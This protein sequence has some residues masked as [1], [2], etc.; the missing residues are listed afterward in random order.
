MRKMVEEFNASQD[1]I[2]VEIQYVPD[3]DF[4]KKLALSMTDDTMPDVAL[5]DSADFKY[6]HEMRAFVDLTE[7]VDIWEEYLPEIMECCTIDGRIYGIPVGFNCSVLYYNVNTLQEQNIEVPE[8]WEELYQ[9]AVQMSQGER[10][11]FAIPAIDSE[12][13]VYNFLPFL[14]T[15]GGDVDH[16]NSGE[17]RRAF[18][19]IR[20]LSESGGMS[21]QTINLTAGDLVVQFTQGNIAMMMNSSTMI[22]AIREQNPMLD[23]GVTALPAL[24]SGGES[25]SVLGGEVFAVTDGEHQGEAIEF[26]RF[27]TEKDRVEACV[28]DAGFMSARQDILEAQFEGDPQ[29]QKALEIAGN[30]RTREFTAEWPSVSY[31]LTETIEAEIIGEKEE[32]V[33]LEDA[34]ERI[35][36]IREEGL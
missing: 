17:S 25:V 14:W 23:F 13:S 30:A 22:D 33:I 27:V 32:A 24:E 5:V 8:T 16:L 6:F 36:K 10:Y 15:A 31:V 18:S 21:R 7:V 11:G 9:A 28:S 2:E 3:E 1:R 29:K 20:R 34:A 26:F 19:L 35:E 4:Q 12:E